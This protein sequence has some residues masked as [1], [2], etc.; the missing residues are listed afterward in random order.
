MNSEIVWKHFDYLIFREY[1]G[2]IYNQFCTSVSASL[3]TPA[4]EALPWMPSS[5]YDLGALFKQMYTWI[6]VEKFELW[7]LIWTLSFI[8]KQVLIQETIGVLLQC[9]ANMILG[10]LILQISKTDQNGHEQVQRITGTYV[11]R[12]E[13]WAKFKWTQHSRHFQRGRRP[14]SISLTD[15]D[16]RE[17]SIFLD[18]LIEHQSQVRK[19]YS[20]PKHLKTCVLMCFSHCQVVYE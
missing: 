20:F 18:T 7:N 11:K 12:Q 17:T 1:T 14:E 15:V 5:G 9:R 16:R 2:F 10:H 19:I 8:L 4:F 6:V 13:K 3:R